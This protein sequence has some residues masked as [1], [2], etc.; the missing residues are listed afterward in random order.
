[1]KITLLPP[2][3]ALGKNW[4]LN[5]CEAPE[6]KLS[7]LRRWVITPSKT[8]YN[9]RPF[10]QGLSTEDEWAMIEFWSDDQTAIL[11]YSMEMATKLGVELTL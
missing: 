11:E 10:L 7:A 9:A 4:T 2:D 8:C 6:H 1:M 5:F 3:P